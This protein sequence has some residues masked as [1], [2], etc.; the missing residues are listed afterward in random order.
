MEN[1]EQQRR[2]SSVSRN[3]IKSDSSTTQLKKRI[4]KTSKM[5]ESMAIGRE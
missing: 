3:S 2:K 1:I 5:K 4:S